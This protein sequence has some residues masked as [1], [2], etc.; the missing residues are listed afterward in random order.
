MVHHQYHKYLNYIQI[1]KDYPEWFESRLSFN[2]HMARAVATQVTDEG[3][4]RFVDNSADSIQ[5]I[6]PSPFCLLI[7]CLLQIL[8]AER[9]G[10]VTVS[11]EIAKGHQ[12]VIQISAGH[13][14][15]VHLK[16]EDLLAIEQWLD[17]VSYFTKRG[18]L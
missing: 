13:S 15:R 11:T 14:Y 9:F 3:P 18:C 4:S 6:L 17:Q 5:I 10:T 8:S 1:A 12:Q 7:M 16:P 2:G